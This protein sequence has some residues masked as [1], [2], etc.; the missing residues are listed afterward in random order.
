VTFCFQHRARRVHS[1]VILKVYPLTW[2][3][4]HTTGRR[5]L[6]VEYLGATMKGAV[7]LWSWESRTKEKRNSSALNT[8]YYP[9]LS[10]APTRMR[11]CY[12]TI[13]GTTRCCGLHACRD[14]VNTILT[15][16]CPMHLAHPTRHRRNV[17]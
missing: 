16:V 15:A 13:I 8:S 2:D 6:C 5:P 12:A 10:S 9:R 17:P 3:P 1:G 7:R 14:V 11:L 4:K